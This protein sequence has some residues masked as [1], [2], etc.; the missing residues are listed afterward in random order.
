MGDHNLNVEEGGELIKKALEIEPENGAYLDS[1]GWYYYKTNRFDEALG[2]LQQAIEK[3]KPEDA[4]VY[5]HLGD[6]YLKL[7]NGPKAIG[8]WEKAL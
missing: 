2:Q 8:S 1:L 7:N 5:E 3:L 6:I 4:V